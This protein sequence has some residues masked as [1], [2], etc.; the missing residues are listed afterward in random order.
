MITAH[1]REFLQ[2]STSLP[3]SQTSLSSGCVSSHPVVF[4]P[5]TVPGIIPFAQACRCVQVP[6]RLLLSSWEKIPAWMCV[7]DSESLLFSEH[8]NKIGNCGKAKLLQVAVPIATGIRKGQASK[9]EIVTDS[10]LPTC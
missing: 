8:L 10:M 1:R 2:S 9:H 3:S 7:L 6:H 4:I 5:Y